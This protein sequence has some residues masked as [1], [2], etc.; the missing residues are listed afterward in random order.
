M[1][2]PAPAAANPN[3]MARPMPR[4]PPVTTTRLPLKSNDMVALRR[5]LALLAVTPSLRQ[6]PG[7]G[8]GRTVRTCDPA[9]MGPAPAIEPQILQEA[10]IEAPLAPPPPDGAD[11]TLHH[12]PEE[13]HLSF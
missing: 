5:R 6:R 13:G 10:G 1:E 12:V 9:P 3:A 2:T 11:L 7:I 4:L 8:D